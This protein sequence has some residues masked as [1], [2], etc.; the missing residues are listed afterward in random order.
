MMTP[1]K[2]LISVEEAQKIIF[3]KFNSLEIVK[4]KLIDSSGYILSKDIKALFDLPSKNNSAMDGFAIR[5]QDLE[6]NKTL[7]VV[8]RVGAESITDH[9]LQKDEAIRIMTG[10]GIPEGADTVIQ[11]EKTNNNPH[12]G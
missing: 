8:G 11:F 6:I 2:D 1:N 3:S 4:K 12:K 9:I 7:K 5:H 10:S